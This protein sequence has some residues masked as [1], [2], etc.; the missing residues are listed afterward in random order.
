[1]WPDAI[2]IFLRPYAVRYLAW[3]MNYLKK[4][5]QNKSPIQIFANTSMDINV[6][7][8]HTFGC[9]MYVLLK[10][11]QVAIKG[12]KWDSK[13]RMAIYLGHSYNHASNVGLALS[14]Q[15][16]MVLPAFHAKYDDQS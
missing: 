10:N 3:N 15:T 2:N 13:A 9:P 14:L 4:W 12:A 7:N 5:N 6:K 16:G 11:H 8:F 1:M